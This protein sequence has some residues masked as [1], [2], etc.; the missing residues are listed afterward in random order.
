MSEV[1]QAI[2]KH[3][4]RQHQLVKTFVQLEGQREAY[5]EDAVQRCK[6][7]LPFTVEGINQVTDEINALAKNGIVPTR[8]RVTPEMVKEYVARKYGNN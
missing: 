3:S 8:K 7:G 6:E 5:I 1:H 4:N 2:T